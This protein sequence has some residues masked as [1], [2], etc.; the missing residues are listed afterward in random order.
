MRDSSSL[1]LCVGG[2]SHR[3]CVYLLA[4][5]DCS[6]FKIGFS[7]NLLQR[8]YSFS[9]RYFERFDLRES[10]ALRLEDEAQAR[11]IEATLKQEFAA[12]QLAAPTWIPMQAGGHTEWFSA[13]HFCDAAAR[14]RAFAASKEEADLVEPDALVG[15][16]LRLFSLEFEAWAVQQA[17][18]IE[19]VGTTV[20]GLRA[21]EGELRSLRDWLDA[22]RSF[23][24]DLFVDDPAT[25]RFVC[26]IADP[27]R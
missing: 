5:T 24:I 9:H 14:L 18:Y 17:R 10:L 3:W 11:C 6:A 16:R 26:R 8:L 23:N 27:W 13:V 1:S 19:N 25:L 4:L 15:E 21:V 7:C 22:Y 20:A 12:A 2:E